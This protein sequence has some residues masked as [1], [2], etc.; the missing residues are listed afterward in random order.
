MAR[1][2]L[3]PGDK[4]MM[5]NGEILTVQALEF[6]DFVAIERDVYVPKKEIIYI[7]ESKNV[8]KTKPEGE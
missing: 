3:K 1:N 2:Y 6:N 5:M 7:I 4:V 8:L